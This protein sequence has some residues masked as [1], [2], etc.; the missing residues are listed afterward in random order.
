MTTE[1][2]P[3]GVTV[4]SSDAVARL[5]GWLFKRRSW[6]PV[7]IVLALLLIPGTASPRLFWAG[8]ALVVL[9][10]A[11]RLWAVHHIGVISRTR[12][13]RLGPLVTTGPFARLRNPLYAG[14]VALWLGF[15]MI[16]GVAW[17]VPVVL[18]VL[19]IEYHAI[20]RWEEGLLTARI[21]APYRTYLATVPRWVPLL[22]PGVTPGAAEAA[23]AA[24]AGPSS[25][26]IPPS[27]F[28]WRETLL[29]ERSTLAAVV[30]GYAL[31]WM[32]GSVP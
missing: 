29:S 30:L 13:D 28:T 27:S 6:I 4:P 16:A 9:G 17:L 22:Q 31:L 10:E 8:L 24:A 15:T 11:V 18:F 23:P 25:P 3:P 20:V 1:T 2:A 21:G 5:G 32:K 7:P 12:S 14:N 19:A 26:G